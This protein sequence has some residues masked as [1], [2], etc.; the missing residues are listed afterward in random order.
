MKQI[1]IQQS[2][3]VRSSVQQGFPLRVQV[4][5]VYDIAQGPSGLQIRYGTAN[6]PLASEEFGYVEFL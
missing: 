4:G 6:F 1:R 5:E 3:T 2:F